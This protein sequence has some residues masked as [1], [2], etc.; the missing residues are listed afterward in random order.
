MSIRPL[1]VF[2]LLRQKTNGFA[3]IEGPPTRKEIQLSERIISMISSMEF[4][5]DNDFEEVEVLQSDAN[6]ES[7]DIQAVFEENEYQES[8]FNITLE[9]AERVVAACRTNPNWSFKTIQKRFP[10]IKFP[11]YLELRN[12]KLFGLAIMKFF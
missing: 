4:E 12:Y 9:Y 3:C 10:K 2:E 1:K 7:D 8:S 6:V 5:Y 11:C